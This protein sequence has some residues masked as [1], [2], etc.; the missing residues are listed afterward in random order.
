VVE[1]EIEEEQALNELYQL[2][3]KNQKLLGDANML[4]G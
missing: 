1:K 2:R 4:P 3:A